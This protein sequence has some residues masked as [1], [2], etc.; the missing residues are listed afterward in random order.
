M[1]KFIQDI[2]K[3]FKYILYSTKSNLKSEVANSYLNWLWWILDPL[4]F[5]LVYTFI[6]NIVFKTSENNFPVFVL[7]GLTVWNF[8]NATINSSVKLIANNKS[9]VDKIYIPKYVLTLVKM[10]TNLFK[11]FISWTLIIIMLLIFKVPWSIYMIQFIP[12]L[13]VLFILSFGIATILMHLGVFIEDLGNVINIILK[14]VFYLSGIFYAIQTRVPNP[15]NELLIN[16]NPIALIIDSFR[17]TFLYQTPIDYFMLG[18]WLIIGILLSILGIK[19]IQKYEN[20]YAKVT[21]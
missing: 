16:M 18:I 15:Y 17:K 9:I 7:I 4:C 5:M 10:F 3:Y 21:K 12:V 8:F 19:T 1:K 20:S 6:V 2:K 14:L 11:M 13:I